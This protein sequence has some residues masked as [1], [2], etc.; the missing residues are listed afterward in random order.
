MKKKIY[1]FFCSL[2]KISRQVWLPGQCPEAPMCL[3]EPLLTMTRVWS[4]II[5][6]HKCSHTCLSAILCEHGLSYRE[7]C[8]LRD[9]DEG[10]NMISKEKGRFYR[11]LPMKQCLSYKSA[12]SSAADSDPSSEMD[13]KTNMH[14][15][16]LTEKCLL[17]ARIKWSRCDQFLFSIPSPATLLRL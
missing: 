12:H 3:P 16:S 11:W 15:G 7:S 13:L 14:Q 2:F 5:Q 4:P 6:G 10:L 8:F 17:P 9:G 1:P